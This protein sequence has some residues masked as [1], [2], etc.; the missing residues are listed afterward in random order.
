MNTRARHGPAPVGSGQRF[1]WALNNYENWFSASRSI[2]PAVP[3]FCCLGTLPSYEDS[4][5]A[6]AYEEREGCL[7]HD[8]SVTRELSSLGPALLGFRLLSETDGNRIGG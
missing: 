1:S 2:R 8:L 7:G 3:T 5:R 4:S 6:T